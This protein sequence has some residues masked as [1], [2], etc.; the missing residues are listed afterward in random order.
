MI[1]G[2]WAQ[3]QGAAKTLWRRLLAPRMIYGVRLA[4]GR[5]LAHSRV[6][7]H[8]HVEDWSRLDLADHVY[9]GQFNVID[10]SGGLRI[11]ACTQITSHVSVLTHSSHVSVRLLGERYFGELQPVAYVRGSVEIGPACFI[12]PHSVLAPGT[13][14][15]KGVL[16]RAFSYVQGEVPDFAVVQGQPACVVGDTRDGDAAWLSQHPELLESYRQWAGSLP[17]QRE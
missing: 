13:R 12:G 16:V 14:L 3:V 4:N 7:S 8:T 5:W 2:W 6:G 10:A 9:I 1:G 11:G 15:G 17:S